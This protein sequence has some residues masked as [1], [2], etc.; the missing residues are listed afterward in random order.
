MLRR[1]LVRPSAGR[2]TSSP[3]TLRRIPRRHR[4]SGP[5][6]RHAPGH[7]R[8]RVRS[9]RCRSDPI[10]CCTVLARRTT[11]PTSARRYEIESRPVVVARSRRQRPARSRRGPARWSRPARTWI[12]GR[13]SR[14]AR[15][16]RSSATPTDRTSGRAAVVRATSTSR[17]IRRS[18]TP[19]GP[20]RAALRTRRVWRRVRSPVLPRRVDA[21]SGRFDR[22]CRRRTPP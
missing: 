10:R 3:I 4:E 14:R 17:R 5:A 22:A 7:D 16:P 1:W 21:M 20:H 12:V 11:A 2:R 18:P 19:Q 6:V 13:S 8:S 15:G 9:E